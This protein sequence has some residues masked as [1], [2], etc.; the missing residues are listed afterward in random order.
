MINGTP[1]K[2]RLLGIMSGK[3]T[4]TFLGYSLVIENADDVLKN[5]HLIEIRQPIIAMS[6]SMQVG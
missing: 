1:E 4:C 5:L 2:S 6:H 3:T